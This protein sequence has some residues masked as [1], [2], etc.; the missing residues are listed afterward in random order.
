MKCPY[1]N[2]NIIIPA[3][4]YSNIKNYGS[5]FCRFA[6]KHCKEVVSIYMERTVK[7]HESTIRKTNE[8]SDW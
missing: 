4:V 5:R 6:C 7:I 3:V 8:P 2:E 1:C